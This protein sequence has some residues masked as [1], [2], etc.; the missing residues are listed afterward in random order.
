[1]KIRKKF[2]LFVVIVCCVAAYG[3]THSNAPPPNP[4]MQQSQ[5]GSSAPA[6]STGSRPQY[7]DFPDIPIPSELDLVSKD[8]YVFQSGA[9]KS[10]VL[11]LRGRVDVNSLINFF[12]M[13]LPRDGW[14]PKGQFRYRRSALIFEK[15]DKTCVILLSEGTIWTTA[16][17]YVAPATGN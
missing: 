9:M 15:P 4:V 14:K 10:G 2:L 12:S 16:E 8:S 7:L 6:P 5:S 11:T 13:A 3:C 1:M 17:I